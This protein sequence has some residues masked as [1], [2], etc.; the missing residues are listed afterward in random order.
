MFRLLSVVWGVGFVLMCSTQPARAEGSSSTAHSGA[1]MLSSKRSAGP[2]A[3]GNRAITAANPRS[4]SV[5]RAGSPAAAPSLGQTRKA[6]TLGSGAAVSSKESP[7]P[8]VRLVKPL[9]LA[10]SRRS[11]ATLP[12]LV[13]PGNVASL[14]MP[15][16]S[17]KVVGTFPT[18]PESGFSHLEIEVSHSRHTFKLVGTS[19]F[20]K[21][22]VIYE[23][24]VGLGSGEFPTPVGIYYVTHIYDEDPWWIPPPNRAWAAGQSR[25]TRVYGGTMAPLLKKRPVDRRKEIQDLEDKISGEVRLDDYGYRFHGTNAPRSIGSNQSHGCVRMLPEDARKAAVLIKEYVGAAERRESENGSFV[26]LKST[27][28][29]NLV[30]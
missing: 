5:E 10:S 21:K 9:Y 22:D 12:T 23:C 1:Q 30:K 11:G 3:R 18:G 25:S 2:T 27:V 24:R 16:D 19:F 26:I 28:R 15:N 14:I 13:E 20:G 7:Q 17:L 4:D 6:R 29:L 8:G